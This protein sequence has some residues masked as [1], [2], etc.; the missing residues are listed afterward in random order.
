MRTADLHYNRTAR[1]L[2]WTIAAL[3]IANLPLGFFRA[4]LR[5]LFPA[6]MIHKSIGLAVLVLS[7]IRLVWRLTH[8]APPLPAHMPAWEKA[9]AHGL[10]WILYAAMILL[11]LSGW[12]MSSAGTRPLSFFELFPVPK[13]PV[14]E[15]AG[16]GAEAMHVALGYAMLA[17]LAGHIG[18]ALRHHFILRDNI[19]TRM[20]R[21]AE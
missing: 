17:L 9:A 8:P 16:E 18:A 13:L 6:M 5:D 7:L 14:G 21:G 3:I 4:A 12:V 19:L 1:L 11:P 20:L 10:H 2:H 15:G